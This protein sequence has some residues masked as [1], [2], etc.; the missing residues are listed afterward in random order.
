MHEKGLKVIALINV[1]H[2]KAW[3]SS[4]PSG[5]HLS[6][7]SDLVLDNCGVQGDAAIEMTGIPGRVAATS[8]I[9]SLSC[10]FVDRRRGGTHSVQFAWP[11]EVHTSTVIVM[12]MITMLPLPANTGIILSTS[13]EP[14]PAPSSFL[15]GELHLEVLAIRA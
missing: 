7:V 6:D 13:K 15:Q 2:A 3:P 14:F 1:N 5:K 4:H 9:R 12:V 11:S 8:M 10:Q